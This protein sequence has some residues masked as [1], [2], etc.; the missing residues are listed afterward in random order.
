M[1]TLVADAR[2]GHRGLYR[3][4]ASMAG[5]AAVLVVLA[6]IDGRTVLGQ[7]LWFK[8]LKF[9]ISFV[10]Y[11]GALAWMLGQLREP[12]M[13]RT[14][15]TIV[16]A[17]AVEMAIIVGQAGRGAQ[18]HFNADGGTGTMLYSVMGATIVVLYLATFAIALRFLREPGRDRATGLAIKLGLLVGLVGMG[19]GYLMVGQGAHA[20]GVPDGGPGLPFVGWSTTGGDL[21]VAHFVGMHGLQVLPLLAAGLLAAAGTRSWLDE[22]RRRQV[23]VVVAAGYVAFVALLTWQ[24]LRAQP[25]LAPDGL[26][27]AALAVIVLATAGALATVVR[28]GA[29]RVAA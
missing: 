16:A 13:R 8:P 1:Q 14:G 23:V 4:A 7:P 25:V 19:V 24:A 15:W 6:L 26:T 20:V 2:R 28:T 10:A 5:L 11:A 9:A 12:A 27:L 22:T 3:L 18:S 21:R 29:H 17:S